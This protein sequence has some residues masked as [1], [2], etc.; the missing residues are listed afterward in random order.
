MQNRLVLQNHQLRQLLPILQLCSAY[1]TLYPLMPWDP[2]KSSSQ[3]FA[4]SAKHFLI[5]RTNCNTAV[6]HG[7]ILSNLRTSDEDKDFCLEDRMLRL[8]QFS[9]QIYRR[10]SAF[11][12][13]VTAFWCPILYVLCQSL[14]C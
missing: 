9:Y 2:Y 4:L 13:L 3:I 5:F 6:S 1:I 12:V 14:C 10:H 8:C 11:T 7:S